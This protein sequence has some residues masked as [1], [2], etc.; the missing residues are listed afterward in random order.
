MATYTN[1]AHYQGQAFDW[2]PANRVWSGGIQETSPGYL[3]MLFQYQQLVRSGQAK[4]YE[5]EQYRDWEQAARALPT[6]DISTLKA[7]WQGQYGG[8]WGDDGW[9]EGNPDWWSYLDPFSPDVGPIMLQL[10]DKLDAGTATRHERDLYSQVMGMASDWNWRASV[11][12]ASDAFNPLGDNLVGA[13]GMLGMGA[14]AG[15]ALAPLYAGAG[16]TLGSAAGLAGTAGGFTS[17]MGEATGNEALSKAGGALSMLGGLSGMGNILSKGISS[18]GDVLS[19]GKGA[20][21]TVQK[22]MSLASGGGGSDSKGGGGGMDT[23]QLGG[24]LSGIVGAVG[25]GLSLADAGRYMEQLKGV[26]GQE[27]N[28]RKMIDEAYALAAARYDVYYA[29]TQ[30]EYQQKQE[31]YQKAQDRY[32]TYYANTQ[33][34]QQQ[35][36][37]AY[38]KGQGQKDEDRT[39]QIQTWQEER[40]KVDSNFQQREAQARQIFD[41]QTQNYG[42]NRDQALADYNRRVAEAQE[43]RGREISVFNENW[44]RHL[45][46]YDRAVA[47]AQQER[48][49]D[50]AGYQARHAIGAHLRD[51]AAIKSGAE[52][53]YQPLSEL[54]RGRISQNAQAEMASRGVTGGG[55]YANRLSAEA[56][57]PHEQALWNNALNAYLQGQTGA[58]N[59][60]GNV[61]L[62]SSPEYRA[63]QT[64]N[65]SNSPEWR[66]IQ[67]PNFENLPEYRA[68]NMPDFLRT[69]ANDVPGSVGYTAPPTVPGAAWYQSPPSIDRN[70]PKPYSP[71]GAGSTGGGAGGMGGMLGNIAPLVANITK[72]FGLGSG[73]GQ[74][75]W[76]QLSNY[77]QTQV[78]NEIN[79]AMNNNELFGFGT[80]GGGYSEP[81]GPGLGWDAGGYD[82]GGGWSDYDLDLSMLS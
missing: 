56:F 45:G 12:Q 1:R 72:L 64:P 27:Q 30:E 62:A 24:I 69:G 20:W 58:L 13:L 53:L 42:M 16:L 40:G 23:N 17:M 34:E 44:G 75:S 39:R 36:Q 51:P 25:T 4:D 47:E 29:Q 66:P 71:G 50:V 80:G 19:L 3:P 48:A 21:G 38:A 76:E 18:I 67:T 6:R 41:M 7:G 8:Q 35:K 68:Q 15:A 11:P 43:D 55:M 22:G 74:R 82:Y 33:Q 54:A 32:E 59:A 81:I 77:E 26:Y 10:K 61:D 73:P 28:I 2:D 78:Q 9:Q 65:W 60:Y 5:A 31:A 57:A 70:V 49:M 46:S 52:A 79:A 37:E 14:G 63:F